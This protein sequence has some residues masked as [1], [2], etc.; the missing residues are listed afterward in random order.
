MERKEYLQDLETFLFKV[1]KKRKTLQMMK[2][3]KLKQI[4]LLQ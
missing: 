4:Q 2:L 1:E 3:I